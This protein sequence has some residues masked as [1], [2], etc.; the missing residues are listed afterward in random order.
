MNAVYTFEQAVFDPKRGV[1]E[2]R[3][4]SATLR[5]R[6]AAVL[7]RLLERPRGIVTKD[8]LLRA[9]WA[10][11]VVT[12]NSLA[13][14]IK[15]LRREL[16]DVDERLIRTLPR[17]GYVLE[18]DVAK[19]SGGEAPGRRAGDRL[20]ILVLPLTNIGGD[21]GQ[22]YFA[23]GL[24]EDLTLDI[25]R[26]PG[27]FV[28]ARG[29]AQAYAGP[30]D[31]REIGRELGVHFVVE[32]SVRRGEHDIVVNLRAS[33]TR[34]ARQVW[35]ERFEASRGN[36]LSL[37]RSMA[38]KV[39]QMLHIDLLNL[40]S[41]DRSGSTPDK[42]AHDMAARAYSLWYRSAPAMSAEA[43]ALVHRAVE[44]DPQC[45]F[46]W[47]M[48]ANTHI[49]ALATRNFGDWDEATAVAE[50]ASRKAISL[51]PENRTA[52]AALGAALT[53]QGR[54]EEALSALARQMELNPNHA[55][56]HQW[57]G[58]VHILMGNARLA[59]QP[60]ETA[61][62]LSPRDPR[63]STFIRNLALAHLHLR[64]DAQ[65]LV[66][67]ERSI[68]HPKPWPRSFE[69]LAAAYA[70]NGLMEEARAAA[71]RLLEHWPRYSIAMHRAEMMSRRPEFL[72]QRE[73][74]LEGLRE[75]GLPVESPP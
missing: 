37:Q 36:L 75:A 44:L 60:L 59:I 63:M 18:A 55:I 61:I 46:A 15:E 13:Q 43:T 74:L 30:V 57:V 24:T 58:I 2:A 54:F 29:T 39:A 40:Q 67:A 35:A 38:G 50:S 12:E 20:A 64:E 73:R 21:L 47:V 4:R 49:M 28:I 11:I 17:R 52:H 56:A 9:V 41:S 65:A 25:G 1:L 7:L 42:D 45:A 3:G 72:V 69:T 31:V 5:P 66:I 14:C 71:K 6:S 19:V 10:D 68:H 33:E 27:T 32:G 62:A 23:E 8:E 22:D 34:D 16:G 53:Y 48:L 26:M 51:D 70:V